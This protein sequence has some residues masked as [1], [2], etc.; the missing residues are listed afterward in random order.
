MSDGTPQAGSSG[1]S[2]RSP[3]GVLMSA[4]VVA[5]VVAG[6]LMAGLVLPAAGAAGLLT[7]DGLSMFNSLDVQLE[8]MPLP[9]GSTMYANDGKT[10]IARFYEENRVVTPLSRIAPVMRQAVVAIEDA[11]FYEH[12]GVDPKGLVRAVVSNE[13]NDGQV[14][15]ASTLTQQ[16]VKNVLLESAVA[17]GDKEAAAAATVKTNSRKLKE[18]RMAI[19]YE[20][21]HS[22]DEILE[23][24]L[25]I[26]NFGQNNYG[27]EAAAQYFFQTTAA[28]LT[29]PQ[30]AL[31]AGLVQI[32]ESYNPFKHPQAATERRRLVL[33]RMLELGMIT[34]AQFD[35]ADATPLPTEPKRA[36]SGCVTADEFGYFCDYALKMLLSDP[37]YA[38]LGKTEKERLNAIKRGGLKI[39]TTVDAKLQKAATRYLMKKIP[40][41]DPS[42]VA[43]AAVTVEPGTGKVLTIAQ[44][45]YFNPEKGPGQTE[46]SYGVDGRY[47]AS[48]GFQVGSNFKP[49]TLATWLGKNKGLYT[50]VNGNIKSRPFSDFT[51]C[52]KRLSGQ[53]YKFDNSEGQGQPTIDVMSATYR[54]VNT[55][56]VDIESRLDMCD[57]AKTAEKMG[58]HLASPG[59]ADCFADGT[60]STKIPTQCPSLTLGAFAISPMTMASAYGVFASDG[61]YCPPAPVERMTDRTGKAIPVGVT[62]CDANALPT[63]VARGVTF[64]LKNVFTR[65][66]ATN[67]GRTPWPAAGKTGTTDAS[68]HTWFTGYTQQR[69]TS[70]V[71]TDPE[72]Y[73]RGTLNSPGQKSL[74]YRKIGG[75]YYSRVYGSTIAAPLWRQ[76]MGVAMDGLPKKDWAKPTGKVLTGSGIRV[77]NVTGRS[78]GDATGILRSQGFRVRIGPTAPAEFGSDRVARTSPAAG[79]R[80][81]RGSSVLL[82]PG[83]GSLRPE[84]PPVDEGGQD[85]GDNG[86]DNGNG[87]DNGN[88]N[89]GNGRGG[90]GGDD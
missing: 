18:I 34:Q 85:G 37:R 87:N 49:F 30:A 19:Q 59:P 44:N 39:V 51:A 12:G 52:G 45:T 31:L 17:A 20:Q 60:S 27:V 83:D 4:F 71:V 63:N 77:A 64:A 61:T 8:D 43:A 65:G 11:R 80:L 26:A 90:G 33:G 28:K 89:N 29:L 72:S 36:L 7:R 78:I 38:E 9:E 76:I 75:R 84:P 53:T 15:G 56:Y 69:A 3:L 24:Y 1:T 55:A 35:E 54:S 81:E 79:G 70:V 86:D 68:I 57:I 73:Q 10:V 14:Q 74:N 67:V 16:Y 88:D 6:V 25:N 23:G 32:P 48:L 47:G 21:E 42:G 2:R 46:V 40:A 41:D 50:N 62:E 13:L 66:T 5:S 22:K 58:V 82:Y